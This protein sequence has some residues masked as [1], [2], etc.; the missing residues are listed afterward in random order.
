MTMQL[1]QSVRLEIVVEQPKRKRKKDKNND[2]KK[3]LEKML[4]AMKIPQTL[5]RT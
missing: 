3:E 1:C 2:K 4:E 5:Y